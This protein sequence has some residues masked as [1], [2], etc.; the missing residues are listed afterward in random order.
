MDRRNHTLIAYFSMEIAVDSEL[1]TYS[2]GLGVLAGDTLR[3]AADQGVPV[4]GVTLVHRKGYF[5][6][7]IDGNGN[8]TEAPEEWSPEK[9]LEPLAPVVTLELERRTVH[10]RAWRYRIRGVS[11]AEIPVLFLDTDLAQNAPEDRA[12]TDQLYG[13]DHHYR[14][15]Q[16][17]LLGMGGLAILRALGHWELRS[18]HMNE[19]HSALLGLALLEER[20]GDDDEGEKTSA[21]DCELVRRHCIFTT[22]TPVPAGHDQFPLDQVRSVLGDA[23]TEKLIGLGCCNE[24]TLNMTSL[25][26][27]FARYVNGVAMRHGEVARGMF[28]HYPIR[29]ITNGVHSPTWTSDS[30]Q[31]LFD[32]EIPD[33]RFDSLNLRYAMQISVDRIR[34]AHEAAKAL[35][36]DEVNRRTNAGFK[37]D[38]LTIGFARRA[39][40][41][42]RADL[43]FH[44]I[45]RL[46]RI[47]REVGPLQ[48]VYAGKAHPNDGAGKDMIRRVFD[49]ARSLEGA[50]PTVYLPDYDVAL[51]RI[52][53]AGVDVWLNTPQKP[54]E[55][56]GTSGMKAAL[57]GVP[58]LSILD[59][60]WIEGCVEGVTGWSIGESAE[61][62]SDAASEANSLY[63]KL[64]KEIMPL[65]YEHPE[66]FGEVMR[67]AIA[68][69][70]SFFSAR[71]MLLQYL[72][73][74]YQ[75]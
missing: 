75:L 54:Q 29:S 42:K 5:H 9:K 15:R 33:W 36:L 67:S 24:G 32:R 4:V 17:A 22:H 70:G 43:L 53:C 8:Q 1:P 61:V 50:V 23:R 12:L 40:P 14:L 37:P 44:D 45:E 25:A 18:Y 64:E 73:N 74:A 59:G 27:F 49:A 26:L 39:T 48:V 6:Q 55:A 56:S 66:R 3:A 20:Q 38:V 2:G 68:L 16:E 46:R 69:N 62:E 51:G 34:E 47:A 10:L 13:G 71:R 35:L 57:N 60:W 21:T 31:E 19:G 28:P 72:H 41:Y 65:Y 30:F 52:L 63:E 7:S 11:G 58:S